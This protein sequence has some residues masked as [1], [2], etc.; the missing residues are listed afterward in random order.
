LPKNRIL[1]RHVSSAKHENS[2]S[3]QIAEQLFDE[4]G[5]TQHRAVW[6][7]RS[8]TGLQRSDSLARDG[9][10]LVGAEEPCQPEIGDL[11]VHVGVEKDVAGL[12]IAVDDS[13]L[14]ILVEVQQASCCLPY[15]MTL[16]PSLTMDA[17]Q[18]LQEGHADI[19]DTVKVGGPA[20]EGQC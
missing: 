9:G 6:P 20:Q 4:E 8:T 3:F 15:S 5:S 12:Q 1:W 19:S 16:S 11:R 13:D 10:S 17:S 2:L 18:G 7:D 14:R